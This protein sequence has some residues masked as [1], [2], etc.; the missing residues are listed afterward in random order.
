MS[1]RQQALALR[2]ELG[3]PL[4][5][6]ATLR[7]LSRIQWVAGD[8]AAA[9][10]AAAEAVELLE[11][12]PESHELALAL[13]NRSQLDMLAQRDD[14][15]LHWGRRA[16]EL[17]RRLGD[18]ETLVHA[19]T[20]V[21]ATL[22]RVEVDAGL[23]LLEETARLA[24]AA[25]LHEHAGRALC[26]AAWTLKDV[27][28]YASAR[29][30]LERGLAYSRDHEI[31]IYVEYLV[32]ARALIDLAMGDWDA[33]VAAAEGLVAQPRLVNAVARIPALEVVGLAAL[34]RGQPG[35]REHL[36]EAWQLAVATAELQRLR[37]I[38]CARAEAAWLDG[39]AD[40]LDAATRDVL[41]LA[42]EVGH[43]WDVGELL[44]WRFR[45]G[46]QDTAPAACPAP[47]ACELAGDALGAAQAW[48][49]LG[50][51]YAAAVALLGARDPEPLLE[52]IASLDRL[53]A[54][55]TAALGRARLR[56]A[57]VTHIPRGPRPATR[58][59]PA[60]LTARQLEVLALVIAGSVEPGDR[61]R[62]VPVAQDRRASRHGGA[63]EARRPSRHEVAAAARGLGI[64]GPT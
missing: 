33:A 43:A 13:S 40:A 45:G 44:L 11:P 48:T 35:A 34:R 26:N 3:E 20:N 27:R 23:D 61:A 58:A 21:G 19:Q 7:W 46:L 15:A 64:T 30:M 36:D 63:G 32:A 5:T 28:R 1:A 14:D 57:G 2:R 49:T 60:G 12:F 22:V 8:G 54:T 10:R 39:E 41:A 42:H 47:I 9:E 52:G 4:L 24:T 55:A 18:T 56:R 37:P 17:A 31:D 53:G 6:G 62:A 16:M 25:G 29:E 51:P 38:A 50:E 59:N